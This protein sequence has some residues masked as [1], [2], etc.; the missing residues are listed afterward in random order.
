MTSNEKLKEYLTIILTQ[1]K[2]FMLARSVHKIAL[3]IINLETEETV[4]RWEFFV[5]CDKTINES[6]AKT[7]DHKKIA[8]EIR[9]VIRQIT[10]S[11]TFLP[12]LEGKFAFDI[13]LFTDKDAELPSTEWSDSKPHLIS[14]AEEVELKSFSTNIHKIKAAVSYKNCE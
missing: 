14:N 4:E 10:A 9:D 6:D 5:D 13:L 1:L 2:N 3:V 11:V 7:V 8:S 12:L